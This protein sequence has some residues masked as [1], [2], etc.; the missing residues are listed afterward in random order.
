[1]NVV[2]GPYSRFVRAPVGK[3]TVYFSGC[4]GNCPKSGKIEA[5]DFKSEVE[6]A[7]KNVTSVLEQAETKVEDI[8][9]TT[10]FLT[11][12][13]RYSEFNEIYMKFMGDHRPA[14]SLVEVRAL[15]LQAQIEM[16]FIA[17]N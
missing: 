11:D 5:T 4:I 8:V 3:T 9:K 14:R 12:M 10:V 17:Y 15:P 7:L 2:V 16:E 1:M 13:N 6:A